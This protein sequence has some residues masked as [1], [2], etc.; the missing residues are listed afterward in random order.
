M[1]VNVRAKATAV[2][3]CGHGKRRRK[4]CK[5]RIQQISVTGNGYATLHGTLDNRRRWATRQLAASP[6]ERI[7]SQSRELRFAS[8]RTDRLGRFTYRSG[9]GPSRSIS[10]EYGG[11]QLV[12]P[13]TTRI[14]LAVAARST[15]KA[16]PRSVRNGQSTLVTGRLRRTVPTGGKLIS[17]QAHFRERRT[18]ATPHSDRQGGATHT[19]SAR[20][21]P[22]Y[23]PARGP[24][25]VRAAYPFETGNSR[26]VHVVVRG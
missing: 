8:I 18:F 22:G 4:R 25:S 6:R 3:Q 24:D 15:I 19:G 2:C 13:A 16:S 9:A 10:F 1:A 17:L 21:P 7:R 26:P 11:T 23:I 14:D 5:K 20:H 12:K